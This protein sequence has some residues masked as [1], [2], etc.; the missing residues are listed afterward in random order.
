[1]GRVVSPRDSEAL[2]SSIIDILDNPDVLNDYKQNIDLIWAKEMDW[3]PI[4]E[5]YIAMYKKIL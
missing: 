1:M 2:A 4:A 3:S 5:K